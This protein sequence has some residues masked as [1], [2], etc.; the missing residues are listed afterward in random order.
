[1]GS[2]TAHCDRVP[3]EHHVLPAPLLLTPHQMNWV[4]DL[5][6]LGVNPRAYFRLIPQEDEEGRKAF[7]FHLL[8]D[9]IL[10]RLGQHR[11]PDTARFLGRSGFTTPIN[12][13]PKTHQALHC[14]PAGVTPQGLG[15]IWLR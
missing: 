10:Q 3:P 6:Q 1:M 8:N 14:F 11:H 9:L 13:T 4:P 5:L 7:L 15:D 12:G 2:S